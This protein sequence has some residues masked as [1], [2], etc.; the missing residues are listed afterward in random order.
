MLFPH[1]FTGDDIRDNWFFNKY[2]M[3]GSNTRFQTFSIAL[4]LLSQQHPNATIIETGCQR[5]YDVQSA[6]GSTSIWAEYLE[7]HNGTKL[8]SI[9]ISKDNLLFAQSAI[10][11]YQIES[12]FICSD[13]KTYLSS[14]NGSCDLLYLDS[15]DYPYG[16]ILE[17]YGGKEDIDK[18]ISIVKSMPRHEI[19]TKHN[20]LIEECQQHTLS[21]FTAIEDRLQKDTILLIDDNTLSGG[22]KSRLLKDY[23]ITKEEWILIGDFYQSLWVRK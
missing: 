23:L 21:E 14:Y 22:G 10:V 19:L 8:I 11:L 16:R 2:Y 9:D 15:F 4:N 5:C 1:M 13:S 6:G 7:K 3:N 12:D 18:A 17:E 20:H